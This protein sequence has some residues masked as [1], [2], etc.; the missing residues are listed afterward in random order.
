MVPVQN[1]IS[2]VLPNQEKERCSSE[3]SSSLSFICVTTSDDQRSLEFEKNNLFRLL[4]GKK[5]D[6]KSIEQN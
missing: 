1:Q 6:R 2:M 3:V 5:E 4:F